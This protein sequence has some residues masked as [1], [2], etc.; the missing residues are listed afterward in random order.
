MNIKTKLQLGLKNSL[1]D[2]KTLISLVLI[3]KLFGG[4][5]L[6]WCVVVL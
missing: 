1:H 5:K 3:F 2:H 6:A 4:G